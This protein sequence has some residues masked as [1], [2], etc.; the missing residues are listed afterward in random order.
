MIF[1]DSL[2]V[3]NLDPLHYRLLFH[4]LTSTHNSEN[5]LL[6]SIASSRVAKIDFASERGCRQLSPV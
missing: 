4:L 1:A 2:L 5:S 6:W 3:E